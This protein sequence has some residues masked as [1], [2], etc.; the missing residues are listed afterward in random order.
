LAICHFSIGTARPAVKGGLDLHL[1]LDLQ[2]V[3]E[4]ERKKQPAK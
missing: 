2:A 3:A 4:Q 1:D